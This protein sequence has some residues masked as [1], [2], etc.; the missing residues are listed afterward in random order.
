[1]KKQIPASYP[2]PHDELIAAIA[3][4]ETVATKLRTLEA[5]VRELPGKLA[6]A[7]TAV[8]EAE[9]KLASK[10]VEALLPSPDDIDLEIAT[11]E[12][13]VERARAAAA[14]LQRQSEALDSTGEKL[15]AEMQAAQGAL[16]L[17]LNILVDEA[18]DVLANRIVEKA[19]ELGE[20]YAA[21]GAFAYAA[22]ANADW[23]HLAH[24]SDPRHA[25][26]I[27]GTGRTSDAAQN[28]LSQ[29]KHDDS[30]EAKSIRP[31]LQPMAK[32]RALLKKHEY[33]P[34]AQ[35]IKPGNSL[36]GSSHGPNGVPDAPTNRS[37]GGVR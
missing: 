1:M 3:D 11:L 36:R 18:R 28:I 9:Q 24:V 31:A 30:A 21:Y 32:A 19:D 4:C 16:N 7:E 8:L 13:D 35:R 29:P 23:L 10:E 25:M 17:E 34:R 6:R 26:Q 22:G 15:N 2:A 37:A 20:L 33:T 27:I 14:R 12:D 5:A